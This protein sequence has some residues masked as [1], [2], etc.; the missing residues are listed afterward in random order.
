MESSATT[1]HEPTSHRAKKQRS[2]SYPAIGLANAIER[3]R[4]LY[5]HEGRNAAPA[6]AVVA[7]WGY[8]P[9][10]SGGRLVLAALKKY[11]L[12]SD[13]GSREHRQIQLTRLALAIL[14]DD[15][16]V[17]PERDTAIRTA[18]LEP[19]IHRE[20]IERYPDGLPSDA[21]LRHHLLFDR[22]FT[23]PAVKEFIPRFRE[24]IDFAGLARGAVEVSQSPAAPPSSREEIPPEPDADDGLAPTSPV[25]SA[26]AVLQADRSTLAADNPSD[27]RMRIVQVPLL[28]AEWVTLQ[29]AFPLTEQAWDQMIRVLDAMKP[30]LIKPDAD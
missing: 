22:E 19:G 11:G 26:D 18:A 1:T 2:P 16:E 7:H 27:S 10:S 25:A 23:E 17:S 13:K 6:A 4:V 14:L 29:G 8:S 21:S 9:K 12:I 20:L 28:D 5:E 3:A 24:T 30:G 15:R